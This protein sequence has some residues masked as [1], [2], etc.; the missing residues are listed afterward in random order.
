MCLSCHS[1]ILFHFGVIV[2]C[3][4]VWSVND[5][6]SLCRQNKARGRC[7]KV[8]VRS[9]IWYVIIR[10]YCC[11]FCYCFDGYC[12]NSSQG[13]RRFFMY[14]HSCVVH[15]FTDFSKLKLKTGSEHKYT[16]SGPCKPMK[17]SIS[18]RFPRHPSVFSTLLLQT[19]WHFSIIY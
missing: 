11:L 7:G 6:S 9:T 1:V 3:Y 15:S 10:R 4:S 12:A 18:K 19:S 13:G 16:Q 5:P 2:T 8:C 14:K 17:N